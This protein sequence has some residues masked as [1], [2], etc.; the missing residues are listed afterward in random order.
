[1]TRDVYLGACDWRHPEWLGPFYPEDMPE[2]WQLA[3][4]QTQFSCVWMENI[5]WSSAD[6]AE[7]QAWQADVG[8]GFRFLVGAN[9]EA[10][11]ISAIEFHRDAEALNEGRLVISDSDAGIIW[12]D[13]HTDLGELTQRIK[14]AVGAEPIYLISRD[15]DLDKLSHVST[16][17]GLLGML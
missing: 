13:M 15:A 9:P 16:L 4:Y 7:R 5:A 3:F 2:E 17:L 12:F 8:S 6:A 1:M 10:D 14:D 11:G